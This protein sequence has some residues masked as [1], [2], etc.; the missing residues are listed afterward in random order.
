ML[1]RGEWRGRY[2]SHGAADLA[3]CRIFAHWTDN[4]V[5]RVDDSTGRAA[6]TGRA[7]NNLRTDA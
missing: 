2:P 3:L 6:C 5:G 4:N 1:I 7:G